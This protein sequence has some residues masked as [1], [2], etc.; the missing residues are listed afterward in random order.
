V[1]DER[2]SLVVLVAAL[3]FGAGIDV[4][5]AMK[6]GEAWVAERETAPDEPVK[7]P[8]CE[9]L[10]TLCLE[11]YQLR[12][13]GQPCVKCREEQ[14]VL[15]ERSVPELLASAYRH[16]AETDRFIAEEPCQHLT[17]IDTMPAICA[18]CGEELP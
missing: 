9:K 1:T 7:C 14:K 16:M 17:V 2:E 13:P 11:H 8:C 10:V 5:E 15:D 18:K 4:R 3:Q 12:Q 6:A